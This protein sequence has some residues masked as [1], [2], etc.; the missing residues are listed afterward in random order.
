MTITLLRQAALAVA[1]ALPG[2]FCALAQEE[3]SPAEPAPV[4]EAAGPDLAAQCA[5]AR[6][7]AVERIVAAD[8]N[9]D[10][11][12]SAEEHDAWRDGAFAVTDENGDSRVSAEEHAVAWIGPGPSRGILLTECQKTEEQAQ[13]QKSL[14]FRVMDGD[15]DGAV[16][17][18]EFRRMGELIFSEADGNNDGKVTMYEF[19]RRL[20]GM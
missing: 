18:M 6:Q 20:Q 14:R 5:A 11:V 4:G 19:R 8:Q 16:S 10:G 17:P 7:R 9:D 2:A 3:A 1:I 13:L 12:I 15:G